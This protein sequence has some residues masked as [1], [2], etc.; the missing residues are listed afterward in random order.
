MG[1]G[2]HLLRSRRLRNLLSY[3]PQSDWIELLPLNVLIGPNGSGKSNL[4]AG[5]GLLKAAAGDFSGAIER[6]G[7]TRN[8][9][10]KGVRG[11]PVAEVSAQLDWPRKDRQKTGLG[12][13]DV[14][15][16]YELAFTSS[17]QGL[18]IE[19]ET[20]GYDKPAPGQPKYLLERTSPPTAL[21]HNLKVINTDEGTKPGYSYSTL[22]EPEPDQ[23]LLSR[24]PDPII[25]PGTG[26]TA[27]QLGAIRLYRDWN[28][29]PESIIRQP[30]AVARPVRALDEDCGNLA[31]VIQALRQDPSDY[32]AILEQMKTVYDR[33]ED[34]VTL[35]AG[36]FA[37]PALKERGAKSEIPITR[38]SDGTLRF[39]CLVLVL[40]HPQPPPLV[41]IEEPE[42]GMHPHIIPT[43]ASL[44]VEA[45]E[46]TQLV[47]TTHSEMLISALREAPESVLV[48]EWRENQTTFRRLDARIMKTWLKDSDLGDLWIRGE[49]GGT[50]W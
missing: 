7:G 9:L 17:D 20:L 34:L 10:W 23:P 40:K 32:H 8:W 37:L 16:R 6:G 2:K 39:L 50:R 28:I 31:A 1:N 30:R 13:D 41:C 4:L 14:P 48:C 18:L 15:L 12:V 36:G 25:F 24:Q 21:V 43:I 47:V 35:D 26:Y 42:L 44:L 33:V 19:S 22:Q 11:E 49:I 29:G 3:G 45:S 38:W 27:R 46:R 5:I